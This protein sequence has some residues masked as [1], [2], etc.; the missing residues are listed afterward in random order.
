MASFRRLHCLPETVRQLTTGQTRPPFEL[1]VV[2][3]DPAAGAED[4]VRATLPADPRIRVTSCTTGRQGAARNH[5]LRMATGDYVAFV[6]DD[7]DYAPDYIER[8]A[9]ALDLGLQSVRCRIQTCGMAG[10]DCTGRPSAAHHPL[11]QGTMARRETLTPTWGEPPNEDREYWSRHPVQGAIDDTLVVICRGPGQHS[12]RNAAQG[13]SWRERF[14]IVT[15]VEDDDQPQLSAFLNAFRE[16]RYGN[17]LLLLDDHSS[18]DKLRRALSKAAEQDARVRL[19][20]GAGAREA[21]ATRNLLPDLASSPLARHA[22]LQLGADDIVIPLGVQ[23]RLAHAGVLTRLAHVFGEQPDVWVTFGACLTEPRTPSWPQASF[24]PRLWTERRFRQLPS[25]IGE[26]APLAVRAGLLRALRQQMPVDAWQLPEGAAPMGDEAALQLLLYALEAAGW[27]HAYPLADALVIK[28]IDRQIGKQTDAKPSRGATPREGERAART[29]REFAIRAMPA[30]PPLDDL[31]GIESKTLTADAPVGMVDVPS[32][33]PVLWAGAFYDPSGYGTEAR[34]FVRALDQRGIAPLLR[35]VGN[36]SERF[37][38]ASPAA[39]RDRVDHLLALPD[40]EHCIGVLHLPPMFLERLTAADYMVARTMFETDGL[41]ASM[42]ARCNQMDEIWVPSSFNEQ[43]FRKAGV[44]ARLV[45]IPGAIDTTR[46]ST[47]VAPLAIADARRTVFLSTIEWKPRKEWQ[48]LLRAWADAFTAQD[49]VCLVF[50]SS[51]PGSSERDHGPAINHDIDEFLASIGRTRRELAPILV[52]GH[53]LPESDMPRLYAAAHAYVAATSGE[54]WGYPYMEA[55]AA[56]LLTIAT[57]WSA[58]LDF[59][60]DENSLL[61]EVER[62]VPAVDPFVGDLS[63]QRWARPDARHLSALLRIVVDDPERAAQLGRRAREDMTTQWTWDRVGAAV[64][65]RLVELSAR[66]SLAAVRT[67]QR[68]LATQPAAS[69]GPVVRWEGPFFTHSSLGVVN[70]EVGSALLRQ[71]GMTLVPRPTYRHDFLPDIAPTSAHAALAARMGAPAPRPADVHVAH[72]W[73]PVLHAP[74]EGAWVLMQPWEYAGLPAEWIPVLRDQADALWVYC[75]WQRECAIASGVPPEKVQVVPLGVD[76]QR[77]TPDGPR[78]PLQTRKRTKLL[79][80]GGIIPRKGM[81]VLVQT[82]L[83]TFT[84]ADDVCLVIKGLSAR[85]AY[86]GNQGQKDFAELPALVAATGGPEIE[87]IG[88]TLDD[89]AVAALYRACDVFVAPFRGEGF[90]LPIA[91]A[92]ASGLPVIVTQVG[93]MLDL[94]DEHTARFIPYTRAEVPAHIV[95]AEPGLAPFWWAEPDTEVLARHMRELV[96]SPDE[97]RAMGA[98]A[99]QRIVD[100]FSYDHSARAVQQHVRALTGHA[101]ARFAAS[102]AFSK[103]GPVFPLD[104]PRGTVLFFQPQWHSDEWRDLVRACLQAYR[105]SD[106]VSLV[107]ALD[108]AQGFAADRVGHELAALRKELGLADA[109]AMDVLLVPDML[110]EAVIASLLR[111]ADRVL[112]AARDIATHARAAAVG[113]AVVSP[114]SPAAL[115]AIDRAAPPTSAEFSAP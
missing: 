1:I 30:A 62:M 77:F 86:H 11:P 65:E 83:R 9:G 68:A 10:P 48:T 74:S 16:Q 8:L 78:F 5:G 24:P 76:S 113:V 26:F 39:L 73:P 102:A 98:R 42:V 81:D 82:Y 63:G 88:D 34:G 112:V 105:Q 32:V 70:R 89:D 94:C 110:D 69:T 22:A 21:G 60:H 90:G 97:A 79:A 45:R 28:Q 3:N 43:T 54:G 2:N 72:Q 101:P 111:A 36:H 93:P 96:A 71:G 104:Q 4:A 46:F 55:M 23:E 84:Q 25:L 58:H 19:H 17:A 109:D 51:V 114:V 99:R 20:R 7:D 15:R 92:M 53:A 108:P 64:Q 44:R 37:R 29:T 106:D 85:W 14:V 38:A 47:P 13:G 52:I 107:L 95:G 56:G 12:P 41:P 33:A 57:R 31:P 75:S 50:R 18:N 49:D 67:P 91:E 115:R 80:V 6:D 100:H 27:A 59:M 35:R 103:D 87:F 61:C 66:P 40:P